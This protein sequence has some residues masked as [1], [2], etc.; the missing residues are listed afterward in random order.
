MRAPRH[1][2]GKRRPQS[3]GRSDQIGMR[4]WGQP[5]CA[6]RG[7]TSGVAKYAHSVGRGG[8]VG[9]YETSTT[10]LPVSIGGW[11]DTFPPTRNF[12]AH[13]RPDILAS[14]S[15][16]GAPN[17][18]TR[19]VACVGDP[20]CARS[21]HRS[22]CPPHVATTPTH[23][24]FVRTAVSSAEEVRTHAKVVAAR[25]PSTRKV[26]EAF[27]RARTGELVSA[28]ARRTI[29]LRAP[30][31]PFLVQPLPVPSR[32]RNTAFVRRRRG[33]QCRS[34]VAHGVGGMRTWCSNRGRTSSGGR[35]SIGGNGS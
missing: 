32:V 21:G 10:A 8:W 15:L 35:R 16:S 22:L 9:P 5:V 7:H 17:S 26:S 23:T 2:R 27:S 11:T 19:R 28:T 3:S 24:A 14:G 6:D 31:S 4:G 1:F 30:P 13:M 29:G 34:Q 33:R 20:A 12:S 25:V 18:Y